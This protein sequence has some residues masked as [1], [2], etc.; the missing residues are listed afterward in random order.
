M[1]YEKAE[2]VTEGKTKKLW[3][4]KGDDNLLIVENKADITAFDDPSKTKQIETKPKYATTTTCRVFE[5]L[6]KAGIPV[7]YKE[8]VSATEFLAPKVEMIPLEC[9][10]RRL[11]VGSFLKR[12]PDY[13]QPEGVKPLRFHR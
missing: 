9:V 7:A 1:R 2:L 11:A 6:Q 10:V 3:G 8:Q 12:R 5:L 4:V 13:K